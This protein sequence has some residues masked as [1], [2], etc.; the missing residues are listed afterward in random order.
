MLIQFRNTF[1]ALFQ[2]ER[3]RNNIWVKRQVKSKM[4]SPV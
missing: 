3:R 1:E 4:R 2:I